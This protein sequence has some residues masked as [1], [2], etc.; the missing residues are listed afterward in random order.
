HRGNEL[1]DSGRGVEAYAERGKT[2]GIP[3]LYPWANR[4]SRFGYEA[5]GRHV[6]LRRADRRIP[7]DPNGLPIHGVLPC[8]MSW[9]VTGQNDPGVI[10]ARLRWERS[11][12]LEVFPYPHEL[13]LHVTVGDGE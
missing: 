4:L 8:L 12:L 6:R 2:M 1:L 5:A 3:L 13:R 7:L 9:E 10:D 11:E